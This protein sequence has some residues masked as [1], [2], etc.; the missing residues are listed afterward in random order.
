MPVVFPNSN[1]N[2]TIQQKRAFL[3]STTYAIRM[4]RNRIA[5]H[6][7]IIDQLR[8]NHLDI[9]EKISEVI[10]WRCSETSKWMLNKNKILKVLP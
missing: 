2:I 1:S 8:F 3:K 4:I 5:H 9:S 10:F 7:P 6:E